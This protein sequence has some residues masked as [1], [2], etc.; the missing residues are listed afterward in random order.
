[1]S[2]EAPHGTDVKAVLVAQAEKMRGELLH[3]MEKVKEM[4]QVQSA[5]AM[6]DANMDKLRNALDSEA[7]K[8]VF[9]MLTAAKEALIKAIEAAQNSPLGLSIAAKIAE[10][11]SQAQAKIEDVK[12]NALAKVKNATGKTE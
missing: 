8:K 10:I 2:E 1:M 4:P 5:L 12:Q 7:A 6:Y 11:Q 3:A 9:A